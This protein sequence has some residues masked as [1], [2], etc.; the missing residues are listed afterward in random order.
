MQAYQNQVSV[1]EYDVTL[2]LSENRNGNVSI[3][4][5]PIIEEPGFMVLSMHE[6]S[7]ARRINNHDSQRDAARSI[8]GLA[9]LLAHE[10]KNPLSGIRGA[11]QLLEAAVT[12]DDRK[13]TRLICEETDRICSLVDSMEVFSQPEIKRKA[14]NIHRVLERIKSIAE[15]G[16][17]KN[18]RFIEEYDPSLPP[19]WGNEDEL[20]QVFLNIV[21]NACEA[22]PKEKGKIVIRTGYRHGLRL[23]VPGAAPSMPIPLTVTISDNG[24][25][26]AEDIASNLFDPFVTSKLDGS[27]LGLAFVAKTISDHGGL[28]DYRTSDVGTEFNIC[29]PTF[30]E[31]SDDVSTAM[32]Q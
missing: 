17:G 27:G 10:V 1:A 11:A 18:V 16:F 8:N 31:A 3:T 32:E 28:I 25:G 2:G 19:V 5:A 29:L 9:A 15:A 14:V 23:S 24:F 6:Q 26:I 13:L 12:D 30:I 21:K 4:A 7:N 20:I 22:V